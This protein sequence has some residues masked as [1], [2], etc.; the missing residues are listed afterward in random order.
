MLWIPACFLLDFGNLICAFFPLINGGGAIFF[1]KRQLFLFKDE[2]VNTT[3]INVYTRSRIAILEKSERKPYINVM[4][5]TY[6]GWLSLILDHKLHLMCNSPHTSIST[7]SI[8][9]RTPME[10]TCFWMKMWEINWFN[11]VQ[12]NWWINRDYCLIIR[13]RVIECIQV[14]SSLD[15]HK[16]GTQIPSMSLSVKLK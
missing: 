9:I 4:A 13:K 7:C 6:G 3:Y 12:L 15:F 8:S 1:Y 5:T 2:S 16:Q 14:T 10:I 11:Q